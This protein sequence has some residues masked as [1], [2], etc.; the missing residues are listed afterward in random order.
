MG[1][2][3]DRRT[4]KE[5]RGLDIGPPGGWKDRRRRVER[6]LMEVAEID[7]RDWVAGMV[8][9]RTGAADVVAP[10]QPV[11]PLIL[12]RSAAPQLGDLRQGRE[13]RAEDLGPPA[14]VSDRRRQDRRQLG[15]AEVSMD[16]WLSAIDLK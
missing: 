1:N 9:W 6:R 4:G 5:R 10:R 16:D 7:F 12:V 14:G 8:R 15:V 13:R 11:P 3:M 2:P